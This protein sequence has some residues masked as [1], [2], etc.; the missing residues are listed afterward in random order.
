MRTKRAFE[1]KQ[2]AFFKGLSLKQIKQISLEG[3]VPTLIKPII[4][5]ILPFCYLLA[6]HSQH[7]KA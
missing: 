1:M 6:S 5:P 2:K 7:F 3:Q 4:Q